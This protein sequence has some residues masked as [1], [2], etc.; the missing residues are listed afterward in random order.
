MFAFLIL[1]RQFKE[2]DFLIL[3]LFTLWD[4][5]LELHWLGRFALERGIKYLVESIEAFLT[6]THWYSG[7]ARKGLF[8]P[9]L[10]NLACLSRSS[11]N[12]HGDCVNT[13]LLCQHKV[14]LERLKGKVVNVPCYLLDCLLVRSQSAWTCHCILLNE[15]IIWKYDA[16]EEVALDK[17]QGSQSVEIPVENIEK[18]QFTSLYVIVAE[19]FLV[20]FCWRL[21]GEALFNDCVRPLELFNQGD[22]V[23]DLIELWGKK[24]ASDC[25]RI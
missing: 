24:K 9:F 2:S 22:V 12:S 8:I 15:L 16:L 1:K 13:E 4:K 5:D 6:L 19:G 10:F 18:A 20:Y 7:Y 17:V 23:I 11:D 14:L 3:L 25:D 21:L